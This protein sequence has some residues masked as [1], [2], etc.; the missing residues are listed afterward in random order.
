M[1]RL[2]AAVSRS[3]VTT[4]LT[5][6]LISAAD[7]SRYRTFQLG[8]DL[9]TVAK[10]TGVN[11][12]EARIIHSRPALVEELAW[13]PQSLGPSSETE[14]AKEVVFSFYEGELFRIAIDYDSYQTEGLTA[15]D[16]VEVISA[17]YGPPAR[18]AA[19]AEVELYS[20]EG[21]VVA[22]WEDSQHRFDLIRFSYGPRFKLVGVLKRLEAPSEA[23][24]IEAARLDYN[25]A[26]RRAAERMAKDDESERDNRQK[27]RVVNKPKFRP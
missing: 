15:D 11:A 25:E 5:F 1:T 12:S 24:S 23:A 27:A 17:T 6:G 3:A 20:H 9:P 21:L 13:R 14:S 22:Q 8:E 16:F 7:L 19:P 26:P 2:L 4:V 18:P 10:T